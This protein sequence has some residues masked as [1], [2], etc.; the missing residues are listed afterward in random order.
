[1]PRKNFENI[2]VLQGYEYTRGIITDDPDYD[3]DT[4]TVRVKDAEGNDVDYA[5]T[6][7]FYHC[8]EDAEER[9]DNGA[10]EGGSAGFVKDDEV[11][12]L[13]QRKGAPGH[14]GEPASEPKIFVIGHAEGIKA[15]GLA[16]KITSVNGFT[17][18]EPP[19]WN[20]FQ[21]ILSQPIETEYA[22]RYKGTY[23]E[24]FRFLTAPLRP[25][26]AGVV[27]LDVASFLYPIDPAQPLHVWIRH[28]DL[29]SMY[30]TT[31]IKGD[32]A[33]RAFFLTESGY[34]GYDSLY[35]QYYG[36]NT[37]ESLGLQ[38]SF[39]VDRVWGARYSTDLLSMSK[40]A[41]DDENGISRSGWEVAFEGVKGISRFG[42][43]HRVSGTMP[44][45]WRENHDSPGF[46]FEECLNFEE[47]AYHDPLRP[48]GGWEGF[49][50]SDN[51]EDV[52][53]KKWYHEFYGGA[54][55]T[56]WRMGAFEDHWGEWGI[57]D[58]GPLYYCYPEGHS[59][60]ELPI[61]QPGLGIII[62]RDGEMGSESFVPG[63]KES[64]ASS[65]YMMVSYREIPLPLPEPPGTYGFEVIKSG[66]PYNETWESY[67]GWE[68]ADLDE[69]AMI[70]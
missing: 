40:A 65:V 15:C 26:D 41:F 70:L 8:T 10:I 34:W 13:K 20:K 57:R 47:T 23:T 25:D 9:E 1:M 4:C 35:N 27:V 33:D 56:D 32:F 67:L 51:D 36:V 6:P 16:I 2:G 53:Y 54:W 45:F 48:Y 7:I 42:S 37:A 52:L 43:L 29:T 30:Y 61:F 50:S 58:V 46:V 24:D 66:G 69:E 28:T 39:F 22:V 17:P 19:F 21:V 38:Y 60:T 62:N 63:S 59:L 49:L 68:L 3:M 64:T 55:N 5:D 11:I 18:E 12:V 14:D 31:D 44:V